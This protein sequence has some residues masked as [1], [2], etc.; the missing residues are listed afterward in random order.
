VTWVRG[1]IDDPSRPEKITI[2][3]PPGVRL[4]NAPA[5]RTISELL[6]SGEIDAFIA[7]RVPSLAASAIRTSVGCSRSDRGRKDYYKRTGSSDMTCHRHP[8][9]GRRIPG[10]GGAIGS[11]NSHRCSIA[12]AREAGHP[13]RDEGVESRRSPGLEMGPARGAFRGARPAAA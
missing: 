4:E 13:R 6:E 2:K 11:G 12:L 1:G 7:P 3:L 5:G 9:T 8:R 10:A